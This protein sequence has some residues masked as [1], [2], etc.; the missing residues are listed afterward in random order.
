MNMI[1]T[2][3]YIC[4]AHGSKWNPGVSWLTLILIANTPQAEGN[5]V[6][7]RCPQRGC[8]PV[9]RGPIRGAAAGSSCNGASGDT[10]TNQSSKFH[11]QKA[12]DR[13]RHDE[14]YFHKGGWEKVFAALLIEGGNKSVVT[15]RFHIW[16]TLQPPSQLCVV[17]FRFSYR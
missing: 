10:S 13:L 12:K 7:W 8:R 5:M 17:G 9:R 16:R 4:T 2:T 1:M 11:L 3:T 15:V 14:D 6:R